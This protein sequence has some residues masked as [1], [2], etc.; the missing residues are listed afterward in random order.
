MNASASFKPPR[1]GRAV[2]CFEIHPVRKKGV[3][4]WYIFGLLFPTG[5][6]GFGAWQTFDGYA[7]FGPAS[8]WFQGKPW[9]AA[10]A[11]ASIPILLFAIYRVKNSRKKIWLHQ[12]G[13]RFLHFNG[14]KQQDILWNQF[15]GISSF[16]LRYHFF[17]QKIW[18]LQHHVLFITVGPPIKLN[19]QLNALE[20]LMAHI[21]RK[22]FP[23]LYDQIKGLFH[24][25]RQVYF[26]AVQVDRRHVKYE[27]HLIPISQ[28]QKIWVEKGFLY[29]LYNQD[30]RLAVPCSK[31]QNLELFLKLF[32]EEIHV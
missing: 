22:I 6:L 9:F 19:H 5:L 28:I 13:I 21:K 18:D 26:G 25:N 15:S 27:K 30:K 8:S 14:I 29:L 16:Q 23:D 20:S 24:G 11:L 7:K 31:I 1:L 2:A 4:T 12:N 10:A 17:G 3:L 32:D